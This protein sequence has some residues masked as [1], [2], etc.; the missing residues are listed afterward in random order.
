M[1]FGGSCFLPMNSVKQNGSHAVFGLFYTLTT[2]YPNWRFKKKKKNCRMKC[3][4]GLWS[5]YML[6]KNATKTFFKEKN[7]QVLQDL[8]F[9]IT[10]LKVRKTHKCFF[11]P[12]H[13]GWKQFRVWAKKTQSWKRKSDWGERQCCMAVGQR[14]WLDREPTEGHFSSLFTRKTG[15]TWSC[16]SAP[17]LHIN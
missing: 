8:W 13:L 6:Q 1:A 5:Y 9:K 16:Q 10:V 11:F 14:R 4:H 15:D 7:I 17:A 2:R 3:F 12:N